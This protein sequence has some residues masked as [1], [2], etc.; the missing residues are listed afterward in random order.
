MSNKSMQ[1]LVIQ[2]RAPQDGSEPAKALIL[3]PAWMSATLVCAGITGRIIEM[4][5]GSIVE[6]RVIDAEGGEEELLAEI[7]REFEEGDTQVAEAPSEMALAA[8]RESE[9]RKIGIPPEMAA[10]YSADAVVEGDLYKD[11][12]FGALL[13]DCEIDAVFEKMPNGPTGFL[14]DWGYR[15]F[16]RA[17]QDRLAQVAQ[18]PAD[19]AQQRDDA[20]RQGAQAERNN[21]LGRMLRA[22]MPSNTRPLDWVESLVKNLDAWRDAAGAA[23]LCVEYDE[24]GMV[25]K[26]FGPEESGAVSLRAR[27]DMMEQTWNDVGVLLTEF[28]IT[29]KDNRLQWLRAQL[30]AR[31]PKAGNQLLQANNRYYSLQRAIAE[32]MTAGQDY[33]D[34]GGL[35]E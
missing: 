26:I 7:R 17:I 33:I 5:D 22:G 21:V 16:A 11:V 4:T 8:Y 25:R 9:Q 30:E 18:V 27:L 31:A 2:G 15:Q 23:E 13:S 29:E 10:P 6:G 35:A 20:Y 12:A 34:K 1:Y 19:V 28:G 24:S 32:V 3:C 14:K